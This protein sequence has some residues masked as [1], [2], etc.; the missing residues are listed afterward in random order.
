MFDLSQVKNIIFERKSVSIPE[1]KLK[2]IAHII[3]QVYGFLTKKWK[4]P[5]MK[6]QLTIISLHKN[7][8]YYIFIHLGEP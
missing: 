3:R 4:T 7:K 8:K 5:Q 1:I 2:N 6:V